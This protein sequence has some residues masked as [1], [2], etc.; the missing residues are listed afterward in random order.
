MRVV[1]RLRPGTPPQAALTDLP[2]LPILSPSISA[3]V[4]RLFV[5]GKAMIITI[6]GPAGAGKSSAARSLAQC[7]G[8]EFLDTGAM[9]RAVALAAA[10]HR[11]QPAR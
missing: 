4:S 1:R 9:Y 2:F 6:D 10:P 8:F 7:L 5:A 3:D 11:H